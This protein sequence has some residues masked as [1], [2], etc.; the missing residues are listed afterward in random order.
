MPT[1][2]APRLDRHDPFVFWKGPNLTSPFSC[3][4]GPA[5]AVLCGFT[6]DGLPLSLQ[7]AGRPF[8]DARLLRAGHAFG[9]ASGHFRR[10]PTL[11]A[12]AKAGAIDPKTW[13][14]DISAIEPAVRARA[15]NAAVHAGLRLPGH[16][17]EEL[18]AIAPWALAMAR[19]LKRDH[20]REAETASIFDPGREVD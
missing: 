7:L 19:R 8:D 4:G 1:S 17:M 10:R 13:G 3:T 14:P 15:E 6:K 16:V 2:A 12:G 20:P 11:T 9:Q 18:V 5:L